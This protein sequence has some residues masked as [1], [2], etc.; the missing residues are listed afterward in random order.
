MCVCVLQ[1]T[2]FIQKG[3]TQT[4]GEVPGAIP[5]SLYIHTTTLVGLHATYISLIKPMCVH[6][7]STLK[8]PHVCNPSTMVI[9]VSIVMH[10]IRKNVEAA[11]HACTFQWPYQLD[12][13]AR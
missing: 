5:M 2:V 8:E 3:E 11:L 13:V 10:D 6:V 7:W 1:F 12:C 9:S 4:V